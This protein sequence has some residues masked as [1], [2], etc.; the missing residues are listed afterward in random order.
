[1]VPAHLHLR[2]GRMPAHPK[3]DAM[4]RKRIGI[5]TGGGDVPGLNAVI[6]S[7]TYRARDYQVD[8]LGVRRCWVALTPL[9]GEEPPSTARY[10]LPLDKED[11]RTIDRHGATM[12]HSSR[13][14]PSKMHKQ[15]AP[16]AG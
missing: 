10:V 11:T 7:V 3:G 12:L 8:V 2:M 13:T 6:K 15:P 4:A 16:L 1:M 5:L 9:D 14:N